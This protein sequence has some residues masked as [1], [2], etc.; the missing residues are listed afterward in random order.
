MKRI[1]L[2]HNATT[3]LSAA[4]AKAMSDWCMPGTIANASSVH[5]EGRAARHAV[6]LAREQVA[7]SIRARPKDIVFTSGATEAN[8]MALG[9]R[10]GPIVVSAIE[11][12]SI[13]V[14]GEQEHTRIAQVDQFGRVDHHHLNEQLV[15]ASLC[16]IMLANNEV[17]TVQNIEAISNL[18]HQAGALLHIDGS[19]ALG[20][21]PIDVESLGADLLTISGHKAYGPPGVG[22]LWIRP[23]LDWPTFIPGGHQERGRRAGTENVLGIVGFGAAAATVPAL[24]ERFQSLIS[25]REE[26]AEGCRRFWNTHRFSPLKNCLPNTLT[27]GFPPCDGETILM[28]LDLQGVS[29]STGSACSAGSLDPSPVLL[30]MG[31]TAETAR[32]AVRFSLGVD[33]STD[34]ISSVLDILE[35]VVPSAAKE[36]EW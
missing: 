29:V 32:T 9:G 34:D 12:P 8:H 17:G 31:H 26:L 5:A 20:R 6:S 27:L 19:Q 11:H 25:L 33:T 16:S 15:G 30:A 36:L 1:Y 14:H 35:R 3:P 23:G 2:D 24:V 22:A 21:I 18:C 28:S 13:A 7:Q 4:A 10:T